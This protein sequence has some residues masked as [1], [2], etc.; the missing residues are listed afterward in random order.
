MDT[1]K[2]VEI[3]VELFAQAKELAGSKGGKLTVNQTIQIE[4]LIKVICNYFGLEALQN[5]FILALNEN[6]LENSQT[7][8]SLK[9]NDVVAVI[10]PLSGG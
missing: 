5:T 8:L 6:Y 9:D 3:S 4:E 2:S 7:I 10:P 1:S